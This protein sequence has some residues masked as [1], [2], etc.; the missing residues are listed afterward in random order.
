MS[1]T[2]D[3]AP[4]ATTGTPTVSDGGGAIA[5]G[6]GADIPPPGADVVTRT[7]AVPTVVMAEPGIDARSSPLLTYVVGRATPLNSTTERGTNAL[8]VTARMTP[9]KPA[10]ALD[11][12]SDAI[13]GGSA[14]VGSSA[15]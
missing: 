12:D 15:L 14:V 2:V 7:S 13:A 5:N 10:R 3:A 9:P 11:G 6:A 4:G 1:V 8:P